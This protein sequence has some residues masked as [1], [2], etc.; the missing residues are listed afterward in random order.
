MLPTYFSS[1]QSVKGILVDE[2]KLCVFVTH[3]N[4]QEN[5]YHPIHSSIPDKIMKIFK[6][7]EKKKKS[8]TYN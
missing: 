6:E 3:D 5:K 1:Y 2:G 7:R 8:H 4:F